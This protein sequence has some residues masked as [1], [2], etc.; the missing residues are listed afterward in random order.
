VAVHS[1]AAFEIQELKEE[2][3]GLATDVKEGKLAPANGTVL[4]QLCNTI[5]RAIAEERKVRD[6]EELAERIARLEEKGDS[7]WAA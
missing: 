4:N 6:T 3:R 5:L 1:P 7:K 2:L